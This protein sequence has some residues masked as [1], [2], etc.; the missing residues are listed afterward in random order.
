MRVRRRRR[1]VLGAVSVLLYLGAFLWLV[2]PLWR[3]SSDAGTAEQVPVRAVRVDRSIE[4]ASLSASEDLP[5]SLPGSDAATVNETGVVAEEVN[6]GGEAAAGVSEE[7]S[8]P[9][10]G[11]SSSPSQS[12]TIIGFEG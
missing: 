10:G 5:E 7:S 4:I 11:E 6:E 9:T 12:E 1:R 2:S 8:P 3:T